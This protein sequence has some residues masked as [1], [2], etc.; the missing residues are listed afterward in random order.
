M[1]EEKNAVWKNIETLF[2]GGVAGSIGK[3]AV[4]P[5][6]RVKIH[7]QVSNPTFSENFGITASLILLGSLHGV[8]AAIRKIYIRQGIRGL[9]QGHLLTLI[10]IFPYA[11]IN[12]FCYD[13]L[14]EK[15]SKSAHTNFHQLPFFIRFPVGSISGTFHY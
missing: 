15:L 1:K 14:K 6:D 2:I 5:F 13:Y 7:F 9:Y 12:F 11:A 3:T 8:F 10:R 4:A